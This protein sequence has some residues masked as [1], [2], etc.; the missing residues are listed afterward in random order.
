MHSKCV[1]RLAFH[2]L[3]KTV[4]RIAAGIIIGS[5]FSGV[6]S[7]QWCQLLHDRIHLCSRCIQGIHAIC[8][9]SCRIQFFKSITQ[10]TVDLSTALRTDLLDLISH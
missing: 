5:G 7:D 3:H 6:F 8:G 10:H 1:S 4:D 9:K 2:Q